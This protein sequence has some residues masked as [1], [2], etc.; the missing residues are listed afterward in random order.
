MQKL[1]NKTVY[2]AGG[3]GR[4]YP[5][6]LYEIEDKLPEAAAVYIITSAY[7]GSYKSLYIGDTEDLSSCVEGHEQESCFRSMLS[8]SIC[9]FSESDPAVRLEMVADLIERQCPPCNED[10]VV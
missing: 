10:S 9:I 3:T 5:F 6:K 7:A 4:Y 2:F 1:E 8:N